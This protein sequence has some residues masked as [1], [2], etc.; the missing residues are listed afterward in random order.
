MQDR[1]EKE[2]RFVIEQ[3]AHYEDS[4]AADAIAVQ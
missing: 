3:D 1:V 2:R 4:N